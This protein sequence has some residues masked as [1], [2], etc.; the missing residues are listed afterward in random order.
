MISNPYAQ[1]LKCC[2]VA[3]FFDVVEQNSKLKFIQ[4]GRGVTTEI[5]IDEIVS[6][7]S[8]KLIQLSQLDLNNRINIVYFNRNFGYPIDVKY[9]EL[10][11]HGNAATVPIPLIMEEGGRKI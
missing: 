8:L 2:E 1:L 5:P 9:A 10:P 11:R 6:N 3:I 7:N 4:K